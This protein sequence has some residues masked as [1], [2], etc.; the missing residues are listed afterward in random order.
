M[1]KKCNLGRRGLLDLVER[2]YCNIKHRSRDPDQLYALKTSN[3][4]WK[5]NTN[6]VK[7]LNARKLCTFYHFWFMEKPYYLDDD[8][9]KM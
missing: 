5:Y 6:N 4:R 2:Q 7:K 9:Q 3:K 1:L 8:R